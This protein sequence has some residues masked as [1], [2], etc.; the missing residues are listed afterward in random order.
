MLTNCFPRKAQDKPIQSC[1]SIVVHLHMWNENVNMCKNSSSLTGHLM[2]FQCLHIFTW[3]PLC[4]CVEGMGD[5][6]VSDSIGSNIFDVLLG[7]GFPWALR[8]LIV[9]YGSVVTVPSPVYGRQ[10]TWSVIQ[11]N[12]LIDTIM[13]PHYFPTLVLSNYSNNIVSRVRF[14]PLSVYIGLKFI[15]WTHKLNSKWVTM[16]LHNCRMCK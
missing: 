10:L 4:V 1:D 9:S 7:L 2:S 6:A 13:I 12:V 3:I 15:R 16:F 5:M 14:F 11:K 8:T